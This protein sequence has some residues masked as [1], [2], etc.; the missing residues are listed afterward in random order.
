MTEKKIFEFD[1]DPPEDRVTYQE[2]NQI[3]ML[4]VTTLISGY[5]LV[6][7]YQMLQTHGGVW[8]PISPEW[9]GLILGLVALQIGAAILTRIFLAIFHTLATREEPP[10]AE[11]ERDKLIEMRGSYSAHITLGLGFLLAMLLLWRGA[12]PMLALNIIALAFLIS[13]MAYY[14][15]QFIYHR[16]GF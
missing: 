11:D 8:P 5:F 12:A 15:T 7:A 3:I 9:G 16:R 13:G 4:V 10:P 2:L 6:R 1:P 14:L